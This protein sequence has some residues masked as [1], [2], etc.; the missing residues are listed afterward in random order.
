MP[1][2]VKGSTMGHG[3][4]SGYR[5]G[6]RCDDCRAAWNAIERARYPKKKLSN[7]AW[8]SANREHVREAQNARNRERQYGLSPTGFAVMLANQDG[9]CAICHRV[10]DGSRKAMNPHVDHDQIGRASCRERV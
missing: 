7:R 10:L 4:Q 9:L 5:H 1:R 8:V 6:C 2:G 3:T